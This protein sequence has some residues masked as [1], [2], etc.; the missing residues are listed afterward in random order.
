MDLQSN[1]AQSVIPFWNKNKLFNND[2]FDFINGLSTTDAI[3]E[4]LDQIDKVYIHDI[5]Q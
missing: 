2:Q 1:G 4:F 3:H 5:K